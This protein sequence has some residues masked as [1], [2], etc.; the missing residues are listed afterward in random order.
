[1]PLWSLIS[2][3]RVIIDD[4]HDRKKMEY[5]SN[6]N[7][8]KQSKANARLPQPDASLPRLPAAVPVTEDELEAF[9]FRGTPIRRILPP[10]SGQPAPSSNHAPDHD[11]SPA[12]ANKPTPAA[13]EPKGP[14]ATATDLTPKSLTPSHRP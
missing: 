11:S 14:P 2:V 10:A 4:V 3:M 8:S 5:M 7:W 9:R 1:M 12:A 13:N 6:P